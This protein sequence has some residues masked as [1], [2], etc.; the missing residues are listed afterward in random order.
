MLFPALGTEHL[1]SDQRSASF[2][3]GKT[4][5]SQYVASKH[6]SVNKQNDLMKPARNTR[7]K[8]CTRQEARRMVKHKPKTTVAGVTALGMVACLPDLQNWSSP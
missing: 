3:P 1:A 5:L 7:Y 6:K 8:T 2:Q 4:R